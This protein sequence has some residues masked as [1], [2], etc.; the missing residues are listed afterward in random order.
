VQ[1]VAGSIGGFMTNWLLEKM[2]GQFVDI[3]QQI[4]AN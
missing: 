1:T 4:K 2:P 3:R